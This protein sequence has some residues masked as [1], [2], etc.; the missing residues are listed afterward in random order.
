[1]SGVIGAPAAARGAAAGI[2]DGVRAALPNGA[3]G[4]YSFPPKGRAA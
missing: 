3:V 1:M 4:A 2:P